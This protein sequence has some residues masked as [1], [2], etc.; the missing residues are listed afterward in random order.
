MIKNILI[1]ISNFCPSN[2]E[3]KNENKIINE[4]N[5]DNKNDILVNNSIININ[6]GNK[7]NELSNG[8]EKPFNMVLINLL[9]GGDFLKDIINGIDSDDDADMRADLKKYLASLS[10]P[11]CE[12]LISYLQQTKDTSEEIITKFNFILSKY[13]EITDI[14]K[15]EKVNIAK[16]FK[17]VENLLYYLETE[18]VS[19]DKVVFNAYKNLFKNIAVRCDTAANENI[20]VLLVK[21]IKQSLTNQELKEIGKYLNFVSRYTAPIFTNIASLIF[22][23]ANEEYFFSKFV[24]KF[25]KTYSIFNTKKSFT[26]AVKSLFSSGTKKKNKT[27]EANLQPNKNNENENQIFKYILNKLEFERPPIN[28][29][30]NKKNDVIKNNGQ[31]DLTDEHV[32][33][34][35]STNNENIISTSSK[36][37]SN[38]I[39]NLDNTE[40]LDEKK[41]IKNDDNDH[42]KTIYLSETLFANSLRITKWCVKKYF[43]TFKEYVQ[44]AKDDDEML[45]T[46]TNK[47]DLTNP[48]GKYVTFWRITNLLFWR[49]SKWYYP[50]VAGEIILSLTIFSPFVVPAS[51]Y[52]LGKYFWTWL[53]KKN[54]VPPNPPRE[55]P[56]QHK[57]LRNQNIVID[58]GME[59]N[60]E[61]NKTDEITV[62]SNLEGKDDNGDSYIMPN[63]NNKE[64]I[65]V[66]KF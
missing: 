45:T 53:F 66:S 18:V 6:T 46:L 22:N 63:S 60:N 23:S 58:T 49:K 31:D 34:S 15:A 61:K 57:N 50:V 26:K 39:N 35:L 64:G 8:N 3:I 20:L 5:I 43:N 42:N 30:E 65:S 4:N 7:N 51:L 59:E 27:L 52:S 38:S 48:M 10:S 36:P 54:D 47:I 29:I 24:S 9:Q 25:E 28:Q 40:I 62:L 37:V 21:T 11:L 17:N 14:I 44:E 19:K 16:L 41:E 13:L 55:L 32:I 33:E 1:S 56:P 12:F 2:K